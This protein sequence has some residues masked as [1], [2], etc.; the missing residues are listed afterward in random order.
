MNRFNISIIV[1]VIG[2]LIAGITYGFDFTNQASAQDIKIKFVSKTSFPGQNSPVITSTRVRLLRADNSI[3]D[4]TTYYRPDGSIITKNVTYAIPNL[5]VFDV[6]EK[7]RQLF[8]VAP[9]PFNLP[10]FSE[11]R[12]RQS[13]QFAGEAMVAGYRTLV[14]RQLLPNNSIEE[15]YN[16]PDLN[17]EFLKTVS[18]VNNAEGKP[19]HITTFEAVEIRRESISNAEFG[20]L[21]NYPINYSGY[22]NKIQALES[23]GQHQLANDLRQAIP[24]DQR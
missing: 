10:V 19:D 15:M 18:I 11:Q 16:A 7:D 23:T 5:G 2:V 12:I 9:R 22:K 6:H 14:T 13:P 21:P 20:I 3:K 24:P 17:G 1:F 8:F 4:E